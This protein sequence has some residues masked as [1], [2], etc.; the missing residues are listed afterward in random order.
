[1]HIFRQII[2][3]EDLIKTGHIITYS[4]NT[5]SKKEPLDDSATHLWYKSLFEEHPLPEIYFVKR[6]M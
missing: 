2:Y 3:S 5:I 6:G 4:K 1:V